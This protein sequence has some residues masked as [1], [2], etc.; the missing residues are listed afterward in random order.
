[1]EILY[2]RCAGIDVHKQTAVVT[3]AWV[4]QQGRRQKQTR[5]F[6]ILTGDLQRLRDWL[7]ECGVSHVAIE[8]TGVYW[9]PV[10]NL[11]EGHLTVVL[12]NAHHVK[13]VPGRKSDVRNSEWLLDLLQHGLIRASFIPEA[14]IRALRDLT[15]FRTALIEAA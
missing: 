6:P 3:V 4:D 5:T 15:R 14:P 2:P 1:M 10:F 12:A 11:L 9:K 8:S 7:S 13:T